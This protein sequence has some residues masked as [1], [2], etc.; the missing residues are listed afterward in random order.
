MNPKKAELYDAAL[1]GEWQKS[2]FSN[3][4]SENC[5]ELMPITAGVAVRDSK[6]PAHPELRYTPATFAVFVKSIKAGEFDHLL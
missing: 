2:S 4:S 6:N 3:G 1:D 5:V